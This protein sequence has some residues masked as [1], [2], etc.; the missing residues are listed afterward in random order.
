LKEKSRS[1]NGE[2][3]R[4]GSVVERAAGIAYAIELRSRIRVRSSGTDARGMLY[5]AY[6]T[7]RK[8]AGGE[9]SS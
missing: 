8:M 2:A 1:G 7:L 5:L 3:K 6:A 4:K 9:V